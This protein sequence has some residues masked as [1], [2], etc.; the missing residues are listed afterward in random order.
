MC[1]TPERAKRNSS[2]GSASRGV[3]E[4]RFAKQLASDGCQ[5]VPTQTPPAQAP[6][7]PGPA[8]APAP[9]TPAVAPPGPAPAPA[10]P[11][12]ASTPPGPAPAPAPGTPAVAPPG[13]APAPGAPV[14]GAPVPVPGAGVAADGEV[15]M[16]VVV[17]VVVDDVLLSSPLSPPPQAV[18]VVA[19]TAAA[20]PAV[21]EKRRK[22]KRS[23]M[24]SVS[25]SV[26][27]LPSKFRCTHS[28]AMPIAIVRVCLWTLR[29]TP[30]FGARSRTLQDTILT[31][32]TSPAHRAVHGSPRRPS[33]AVNAAGR[34]HRR[35]AR[36]STSR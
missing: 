20:I 34:S 29:R 22:I 10:P 24:V 31:W 2:T 25:V 19:T 36:R 27:E 9:G 8:P 28:S 15:V 30:A 1:D 23:V 5:G 35:P 7:P 4:F 16:L 11:A 12:P 13:P 21:T 14:P 33:S 32:T 6:A 26:S 18:S 17:V 3:L